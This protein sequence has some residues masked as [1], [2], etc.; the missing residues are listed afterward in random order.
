MEARRAT[1][2]TLESIVGLVSPPR[3]TTDWRAWQSVG[4]WSHHIRQQARGTIKRDW[5]ASWHIMPPPPPL[6]TAQVISMSW[7]PWR[8][9]S[10]LPPAAAAELP[11]I[12]LEISG[13]NLFDCDC[14]RWWTTRMRGVVCTACCQTLECIAITM[15]TSWRQRWCHFLT[16]KP[17]AWERYFIFPSGPSFSL[18]LLPPSFPFPHFPSFPS[19][20]L[21][22]RS[23]SLIPLS[24]L[25][26]PFLPFPLLTSSSFSYV[27]SS[28]LPFP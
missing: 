14:I 28:P 8:F 23:W 12:A 19:P 21:F 2:T 20:S 9:S 13:K 7:L 5:H 11:L 24:F 25:P 22:L 10:S 26:I 1:T 15:T 18:S 27:L 6:S 3:P 4:E 16:M 17:R